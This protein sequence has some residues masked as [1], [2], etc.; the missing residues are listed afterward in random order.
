MA[1]T[2]TR[3]ASGRTS[4]LTAAAAFAAV[5]SLFATLMVAAPAAAAD[6]ALSVNKLVD[7]V[8]QGSYEPGDEFTYTITVGCDDA[9]C[10][11]AALDDEVPAA[12]A[13]F[14]ILG[15]AVLPSS[16]AS[17][18]TLEGCQAT[19]TAD[20][21][22]SVTFQQSLDTGGVGIR[23]GD[24]YQITLTLKVPQDLSPMWPSNGQAVPNTATATA[25][26]ADPASDTADVTVTIPI[27]VDVAVGKT[28][29]PA[30]QQYQPG[31]ASTIGLS[32][33][34]TSN[35]DAAA[36]ALQEPEGA[37]DGAA[38]LGA[39]NPFR[40]V[41]FTGFGTVSA[42][43]GADLVAVDA[44]VYNA[45]SWTWVSGAPTPVA[46]ISLPAGVAAA[47]VAG[48][49]VTF[50]STQGATITAGG[51]SG[52]VALNVAQRSTERGTDT[53]LLTGAQVTNQVSGTV[54]VPG[55]A[56]VTRTATAPYTI[57]GL[58]VAV[59]ATK[60]I[61]PAR[62]PSGTSATAV[63]GARN[64]S[65]G[66]LS[67]LTLSDSDYFTDK[68]LFAGFTAPLAYPSGATSA[69]VTWTFSDGSTVDVPFGDGDTPAAPAPPAGAHLTGFA[70]IFDGAIAAGAVLN[71][72]YTIGTT[73]D[74]VASEAVSPLEVPN[75]VN[76]SGTNPAGQATD[77]ATAPLSV[78]YPDIELTLGKSISPAEPVTAGGSVVA[79]L[80]TTT[81]TDSAFV[82]PSTIVVEDVWRD[83]Q[84]DDFWNAFNATGIAPTQVLAGSTLTVEA[85]TPT[86]W[87]QVAVFTPAGPTEVFSGDF[88]TLA[89]GIDP[90]TITGL[91]FTFSDSDGFPAGTSVSPNIVFEARST[92]R[93]GTGPTATPGGQA[94]QYQ[95]VATAQAEGIVAGGTVVDSDQV[96]DAAPA[97]I[98]AFDGDGT[99]MA[100]KTWTPSLLSSQSG[101]H[102]TSR[103]GWGVTATGFESVTV[104]DPNGG[105]ATPATTVFQAFDLHQIH[106]STDSRWQ[107]DTVA[108]VELYMNGAWSAV[109]APGGSWMN[110][111]GFKGH[112]LTAAESAATTGVKITVV[113]NDA[114]RAASSDPLRPAPGSGVTPSAVGN[115]RTF[116]LVWVL[117]NV[118]RVPDAAGRWVTAQHGYN[119]PDPA[120]IWNTVGV[121][122]VQDGQDVGPLSARDNISLIDQP[123]A[124]AVAKSA[125]RTVVP[126]PVPGEVPPEGYPQ[127]VYT[128]TAHNDST[129]RAS[130]L[131]VTDPMPCTDAT[132]EECASSP[133]GWADNPYG[134]ATYDPTTNPF[135]R[136]D[137][138]AIAFSIPGN[139]GVAASLSAVTLWKRAPN[140]SLSVDTMSVTAAAGL[141]SAQLADVV[142]VSVVYQGVDPATAGGTIATGV[143]LG[144]TLTTRVRVT[145]RSTGEDATEPVVVTN[146]SFAQSYDPV[147]APN[148]TPY[149]TAGD[150]VQ[151]VSGSLDVTAVKTITPQTLLERDRANPV[152][153]RLEATDGDAT[154]AT[155][156]V[157]VQDDDAE[158]WNRFRL[159]SLDSVQ[160]PAGADR[161]RVDLLA[162]G[163]WTEGVP[164]ATPTLPDV[165]LADVTGIRF[166]FTRADG[167]VFSHT[168]PPAH[169]SAA[170]DLTVQLLDAVRGTDDPIPFPSTIANTVHT[171][172]SRT[173][174]PDIYPPATAD[175]NDQIALETGTYA[176]DVAKQPEDNVHTVE[177]MTTVPWTLEFTNAG[178]G[179]LTIDRVTDTLP[180]SLEPDFSSPPEFQTSA[181]GL[182]STDVTFSYDQT[183]RQ[184]L[185]TWPE[186]GRRMAPGETFTV[187]LGIVLQPGLTQ[188][189]RA[190]NQFVVTTAQQLSSC[191]N[192]SANGQGVVSGLSADECGTTNY[193]EPIPGA[194]LATLKGVRGEIDGNLVD[195]AVNT[196]T[197]GGP[198][199]ADSEGYYRSPCAAN[200]VVGATDAW[201]LETVNSGTSPY[202]SLTIVEPL[203]TPGDRMLATGAA[204]GSTYRPVFDG[205][206]G[207]DIT[208]PVGTTI[209]WE[210]TTD[211]DVCVGATGT[212]WTSDPTCQAD[213][214]TD[215]LLFTGDWSTVTGL[216]VVL[217]FT[218]TTSGTLAPGGAVTV[219]FQTVN[220]PAT[221]AD[222]DLA[223]IDVPVTDQ[224]AWNQFGAQSVLTNN[225]TLRRAPVKAGVTLV[226]GPIE[227]QKQISGPA[228]AYAADE[229]RADVACTA[230]GAALDLGAA[231]TVTL[232]AANDFTARIDG[233]PLG[234]ECTVTEQGEVGEFGETSRIEPQG[235][236][237]VLASGADVPASQIAVITNV[238]EFGALSITKQVDT[239]ATVGS[240]GPFSFELSC[241]T[242]I[243]VDVDLAESDRSF[244]LADAQTHTVTA[245]T[246]PMGST[247]VVRETDADDADATTFTGSGVTDAGDG[248][249]T[250]VVG[251][252]AAV[253]VTN[254]YEAG[255]LSVLKTVVG[256]GAADYGAG[257]F[258]A[259]VTCTYDGEVVY[260]E[261]SLTIVPDEPTLV[262][263]TFPVGSVCEV[264]EVLTGGATETE[265]PPAVVIPGPEDGQ[266]VGAITALVTNDFRTGGLIIQKERVGDGV[267]EFGAGPFEAQAVCTWVKDG[268]TLT[269]PLADGGLVTLSEDDDYEA[270]IDG[271]LVGAECAVT[272]TDPGLATEVTLTPSDGTVTVLDPQET[273]DVATVVIT[274]QFDIG[275]LEIQK[276]ADRGTALVGDRVRYTITLRNTGQIDATDLTVTDALPDAA[277]FVAANPTARVDGDVVEWTV[278]DL[279]AGQTVTMTVDVRF[280]RAG[281]TV[282]RAS[283]TNPDGPWRPVRG[284]DPCPD[285]DQA[286]C[287]AVIV[288]EPLAT[289]G[290]GGWVVPAALAAALLAL[291]VAVL[292]LRRR[293]IA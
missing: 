216:R 78:F 196:V 256:D 117:R 43:E 50:S 245:D 217:D 99:L 269:I 263:E 54:T 81:S 185:F 231:A 14:E 291:G 164:A 138:T 214:W 59:D 209:R 276:S 7:G 211:A 128:V 173:T 267:E 200:T 288:T 108:S 111:S 258:A 145:E 126:I 9:D 188:G 141:T 262:P 212:R 137:L 12:F 160:L 80:P 67:T 15:T 289:T 130:Y 154:V 65:N 131:R 62:I 241:T 189:Q 106:A 250:V 46:G 166:V 273:Q 1:S 71:A 41:D 198:C 274:N 278:D 265:N 238:Y 183:T 18:H 132:V 293:R 31:V 64:D 171:E 123:P 134:G 180:T 112:T 244:Q 255:T 243:G 186:N 47:D 286:V 275:Q 236:I 224:Y 253:E 229:F 158:F 97:E 192:T 159:V 284:D 105:E 22:L 40:L 144:M 142:G 23:A 204:R 68:L 221:P 264:S 167:D 234:S 237:Q 20:C 8:E 30:S 89:P 21:R 29:Q 57:G 25:D 283:V 240:F 175:G 100:D 53:P 16:Q 215:H 290:G 203:P 32:V 248:S 195:G 28:W 19:V 48:L 223:P 92:L 151:L 109:A 287:A 93:D 157:M 69:T 233:I 113:P 129:S 182:L 143:D 84:A 26:T 42:P 85:L 194:S 127:I 235:P 51:S 34:N 282:N 190:T 116:D 165:P 279:P 82:N 226:S 249:A 44:Y 96:T 17:T 155:Q 70:L 213:S 49:R 281:D 174:D 10:L 163:A 63:I 24:T 170:A 169:W 6:A 140:G 199:V 79:Q 177:A 120:T 252:D 168:A 184:I 178:T 266:E 251:A 239:A 73:A 101:A 87:Q 230:A 119:D 272:E 179:F 193:V 114:A 103:L 55:N 219:R 38:T 56:P 83:T 187:T 39:S 206:T 153:V 95:N 122:G 220:E 285:D 11:N 227:V 60:S 268:E 94:R 261:P 210:V 77:S 102:A 75:T 72:S 148:A 13:G 35:V 232:D 136:V 139:S 107:W 91:R 133:T 27:L 104:A 2:R 74:L 246:I 86:G 124:V 218:T 135:E 225:T 242:S 271:I 110:A 150:D 161:V 207:L 115:H 208:A 260:S 247:C 58:T 254:R 277:A 76:V 202:R 125:D 152:A 36:L 292:V 45:G 280:V 37:T 146:D 33:G 201:K 259:A 61:S 222:P 5:L 118:V 88:A 172:S 156:Q 257:P 98:V 205:A 191:T 162:G 52:S 270:R 228:A 149:D 4:R 3:S 147:L 90:T 121:S 176:L 197:P 181:G 66:P